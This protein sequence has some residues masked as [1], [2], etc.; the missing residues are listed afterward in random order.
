MS[1]NESDYLSLG[2]IT[3]GEAPDLEAPVARI[4]IDSNEL[5]LPGT[6]NPSAA[7]STD[8]RGIVTYKWDLDNDGTTDAT[9]VTA[10]KPYTDSDAGYHTIKLT[11]TDGA[12]NTD[13]ATLEIIAANEDTPIPKHYTVFGAIQNPNVN[14]GDL[15]E[16]FVGGRRYG[17]SS[18]Q[19]ETL[20]G[21]S[22][23]IHLK[24]INADD[25][26]TGIMEHIPHASGQ[27]VTIKVNGTNY[28]PVTQ[29][30][31]PVWRSGKTE[32]WDMQP[33]L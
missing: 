17:S 32:R 9:G 25:P 28:N 11:V 30:S 14:E 33:A 12:G 5:Y 1:N 26:N 7:T 20:D 13:S 29:G 8:N 10:A 15:V 3:V 18:V 22:Q 21:V 31:S 2:S 6:A 16:Y 23:K 24:P 4:T 27:P 19:T